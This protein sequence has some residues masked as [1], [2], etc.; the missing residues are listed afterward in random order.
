MGWA[1]HVATNTNGTTSPK[2]VENYIADEE[3][4]ANSN[5]KALSAIF[6]GLGMEQFK[7]I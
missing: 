7:I 2:P 6:S 5:S 3:R 4:D 1:H